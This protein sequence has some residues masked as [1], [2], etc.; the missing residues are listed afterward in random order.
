MN[1]FISYLPGV[2]LILFGIAVALSPEILVILVSG[3]F[4]FIGALLIIWAKRI[5]S[6]FNFTRNANYHASHDKRNVD[7]YI[8]G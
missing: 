3:F 6:L 2:I 8:D 7:I 5:R 1:R 4:I